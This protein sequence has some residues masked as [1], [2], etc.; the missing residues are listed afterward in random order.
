MLNLVDVRVE[1]PES[2]QMLRYEM[3]LA[4]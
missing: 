2:V 3:A 4:F 1:N